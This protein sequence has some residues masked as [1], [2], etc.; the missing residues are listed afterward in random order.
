MTKIPTTTKTNAITS[1]TKPMV[2]RKNH[3]T[4]DFENTEIAFAYKSDWELKKALWLLGLMNNSW[5]VNLGTSLSVPAVKIGLPFAETAIRK[6][7]FDQFVGGATLLEC[8]KTIDKLAKFKVKTILD[9]GAE[10]K[11][12]EEDF[13]HTMNETIRAIDF[14]SKNES[15]P[16]VSS[17]ITGLARFELLKHL[18]DGQS[19]DADMQTEYENVLKRIDAICGVADQKGVGVYF[20]AEES[21]IQDAIDDLVNL[22]M[23][24][25]NRSKA[26]VTNTF[27]MYRSDRLQYLKDSYERARE[28]G[29]LL[30]AK[31]VRGAYMEKERNRAA[32]LGYPSPIQP[33]LE[34]TNAAFNEA[35]HFCVE[36]FEHISSCNAS[37]NVNSNRIQAE[38]ISEKSIPNDHPHLCFSQLYGMSDNLT[39]NLAKAGFNVAK[40][41]PYGPVREVIPYLARRAQENTAVTG[42]MSREYQLVLKEWKRRKK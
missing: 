6:T 27:Q 29:Y 4:I 16:Y 2:E 40:Y 9:Y 15:V 28:G 5:L 35:V 10:G 21:W 38:L 32:K 41:V 17:K 26:V 12:T 13:N 36:H 24:R 8:Q 34:A 14:A 37:H 19:L 1:T 23:E 30:G 7:I 31:L 11:E 3:H 25:Y 33:N 22:M 18:Q 20:D 39:F 42:D